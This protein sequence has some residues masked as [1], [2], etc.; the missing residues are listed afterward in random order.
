MNF[1]SGSQ[2]ICCFKIFLHNFFLVGSDENLCIRNK[3][4]I[5][6][7]YVFYVKDGGRC[8]KEWMATIRWLTIYGCFYLIDA[9]QVSYASESAHIRKVRKPKRPVSMFLGQAVLFVP[10]FPSRCTPSCLVVH[11]GGYDR[12][13]N[14]ANVS[15]HLYKLAK[16]V[17]LG[18]SVWLH[19]VAHSSDRA[20]TLDSV[21]LDK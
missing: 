11:A 13:S 10:R 6:W 17:S 20:S 3:A 1:L 14:S 16:C 21:W 2:N 15:I 7:N 18:T 19:L 12:M 8:I 4:L 5:S 9:V